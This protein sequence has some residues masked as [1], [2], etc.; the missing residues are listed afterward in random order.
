[1]SGPPRS[2]DADGD[3]SCFAMHVALGLDRHSKI[4]TI[5]LF[6]SIGSIS[7]IL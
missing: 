7:L 4:T 2:G 3:T 1:M 5:C 6:L